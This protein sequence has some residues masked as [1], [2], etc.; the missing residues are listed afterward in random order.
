[1]DYK[2]TPLNEMVVKTSRDF[3]ER[4]VPRID[5]YMEEMKQYPPDLMKRYAAARMLA[6]NVPKEYGGVGTTNL[7]IILMI[8]EFGKTATTCWLPL[9]MNNSAPE[10]IYHWGTEE[11][12]EKFL[13]PMGDGTSWASTAFTE[14]NTG[15]D[16]R[17]LATVAVPNGN[18]YILN[19]TKRF[20]SMGSKPGYG[21]FYAKDASVED[22]KRNV[23]AF[24]VDKGS[25]GYSFSEHY[26]LMGLDHADTCDVLLKNVRVPKSQVLGNTG[27]GFEILLRWIAGERIQQASYGVG[28]GEA[29]LSESLKY[30]KQRV[31]GGKPLGA[32]QGFQW[33]LAEMKANI[34]ASRCYVR[35]AVCMQDEGEPIE[36]VSAELKVFTAPV[37]LEVARVALQ[38]HGSYGYSKEYR[39]E[40]IIRVAAAAGVMASSTEIN[41]TIV[42]HSLLRS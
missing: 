37:I 38:I 25:P 34:E 4:Q 21:I 13:P 22:K 14:P 41:K 26:Q 2:L 30:C 15:S 17:A 23:T 31:V 36:I 12:R 40:K 20:V 35:K 33:M 28:L 3:C 42:G 1:M 7:N 6:M 29:A 27:R 11:Q 8:E 39:V 32:M 19:G 9:G 10:T 24:I 16:P 5:E 18:D